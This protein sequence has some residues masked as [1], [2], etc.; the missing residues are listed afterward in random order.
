MFPLWGEPAEVAL[1]VEMQIEP[2]CWLHPA[3]G[4][5]AGARDR[6]N[7]PI[8]SPA[9]GTGRAEPAGRFMGIVG[10]QELQVVTEPP[11]PVPRV[12]R[13]ESYKREAGRPGCCPRDAVAGCP[14]CAPSRAHTDASPGSPEELSEQ[15]NPNPNCISCRMIKIPFLV[16]ACSGSV[17]PSH[18]LT[19]RGLRVGD[20]E[21]NLAIDP[22]HGSPPRFPPPPKAA[23][24]TNST[25]LSAQQLCKHLNLAA[26]ANV[27]AQATSRC[28]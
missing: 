9:L 18:A 16:P 14:R 5:R 3:L 13:N 19:Q 4:G 10:R 1:A 27:A 26:G 20:L 22:C 25:S 11:A 2:F 23:F 24:H 7:L 15:T 17:Q 21:T 6:S 8:S 12:C 28:I